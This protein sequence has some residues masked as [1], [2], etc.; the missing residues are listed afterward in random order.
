MKEAD[1]ALQ[2]LIESE[3]KYR[4]M[5]AAIEDGI[6]LLD[7]A[8]KITQCN[9]G[10][11]KILGSSRSVILGRTFSEI[12]GEFVREDGSPFPEKE[13]PAEI[14]L[15]TGKACRN[16]VMG[17][18]KGEETTWIRVSSESLFYPENREPFAVLVSLSDIS[19]FKRQRD[20]LQHS[21]GAMRA[22]SFRLEHAREA[23]RTNIAREIHDELGSTLTSVKFD[24]SW[25]AD[26]CGGRAQFEE[27]FRG[28]DASIRNVKKICNALRPSVLDDLGLFAAVKWQLD[29]F[30][31][32]TGIKCR[33]T[34]QGQEPELPRDVA[35]G[36]FRI[37]QEALT[38]IARHAEAKHIS[39]DFRPGDEDFLLTVTDDGRGIDLKKAF[40]AKSLGILGMNERAQALGG[41]L[42]LSHAKPNGTR[43]TLSVPLE[44]RASGRPTA[45]SIP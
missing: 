44:R 17:L 31:K 35:T 20:E 37:F 41:T 21:Y 2:T 43:V 34:K 15:S 10:S 24:L 22:L 25:A 23:E 28:L 36:I 40:G 11:E 30:G 32:K 8:G 29:H 5:I 45:S 33:L 4:A 26:K 27:V 42:S 1:K 7:L 16:M 39:V 3:E 6:L 13:F 12:D 19:E 14:V 38:N 18:N 9:P